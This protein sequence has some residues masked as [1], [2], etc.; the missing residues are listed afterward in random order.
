MSCCIPG[1]KA[2]LYA[3]FDGS[4]SYVLIGGVTELGF[5]H[6]VDSLECTSFDSGGSRSFTPNMSTATLSVSAN[7]CEHDLGQIGI[8]NSIFPYATTFKIRF[9]FD[10]GDGNAE[11]FA[12]AFAT[13]W[14]ASSSVSDKAT[15][16]GELQLSGL[17]KSSQPNPFQF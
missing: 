1:W 17:I 9:Y 7:R 12:D 8:E 6:Q 14:G 2:K 13:S 11:Y 10:D 15:V 16:S 4:E 5:D 3:S